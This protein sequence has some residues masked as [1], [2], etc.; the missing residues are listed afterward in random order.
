VKTKSILLTAILLLTGVVALGVLVLFLAV[1]PTSQPVQ[2]FKLPN[3][4][5]VTLVDVTYGTNG[6]LWGKPYQKTL[7]RLLPERFKSYSGCIRVTSGISTS[8]TNNPVFWIYNPKPHLGTDNF[9]IRLL[10]EY[11]W[12]FDPNGYAMGSQ[13][14]PNGGSLHHY[15]VEAMTPRGKMAGFVFYDDS[16]TKTNR[17]GAFLLPGRT[18]PETPAASSTVLQTKQDGDMTFQLVSLQTGFNSVPPSYGPPPRNGSIFSRAVFRVMR[19]GRPD[20]SWI[21]G[22]VNITGPV[23]G[24]SSPTRAVAYRGDEIACNFYGKLDPPSGPWKLRVDFRRERDYPDDAIAEF[25]NV[26]FPGT[27]EVTE[28]G[29]STNLQGETV[30]LVKMYGSGSE[31]PAS[32]PAW[33]AG[34]PFVELVMNPETSTT[35][36]RWLSAVDEVGNNSSYSFSTG[37][38]GRYFG[39]FQQTTVPKTVTIKFAVYRSR[40]M[41]FEAPA[42]LWSTNSAQSSGRQE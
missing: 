27:G 6:I 10:D 20:T 9:G 30:T 36:F 42:E 23:G 19:D 38:G 16:Q 26:P 41:E 37:T 39:I 14:I 34:R 21:L 29:L 11:G 28:P 24:P 13:Y 17:L 33:F 22:L 8:V 1:Q 32:T 25:R 31:R 18:K 35:H 40:D 5:E 2:S 12:E 7:Y 15:T 3:G 4:S